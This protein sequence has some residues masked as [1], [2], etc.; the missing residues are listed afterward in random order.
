LKVAARRSA[1]RLAVRRLGFEFA[2]QVSLLWALA[3]PV[4]V[5]ADVFAY[6]PRVEHDR[7]G[8]HIVEKGAI[9]AHQ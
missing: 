5:A 8:D 1:R 3:E 7:A 4:V 9:V 6:V 2:F